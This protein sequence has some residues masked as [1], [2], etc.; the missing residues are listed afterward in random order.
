MFRNAAKIF[1]LLCALE[2]SQKD[3]VGIASKPSKPVLTYRLWNSASFRLL[4]D[5]S[6]LTL[7]EASYKKNN[8]PLV[9]Y[10]MILNHFA[11]EL[12]V[13]LII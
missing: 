9:I 7:L 1:G 3:Q 6:V 13:S 10:P 5:I 11:T 8:T 2:K 4:I 12:L